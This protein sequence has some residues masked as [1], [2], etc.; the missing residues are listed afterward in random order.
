MGSHPLAGDYDSKQ[1]FIENTFERIEKSLTDS[2]RMTVDHILVTDDTAV[3]ELSALGVAKNGRPF[4]NRYCWVARFES[5]MIVEVRSYLD[6]ELILQL[7]RENESP[8]GTSWTA[9]S[10]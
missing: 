3:V 6:S 5:D 2:L 10:S 8:P 9:S 4:D 1:S 7:I